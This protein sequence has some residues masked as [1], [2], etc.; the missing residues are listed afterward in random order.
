MKSD[1]IVKQLLL[2]CGAIFSYT[3]YSKSGF[4]LDY[5][6]CYKDEGKTYFVHIF[7]LRVFDN[8]LTY[9]GYSSTK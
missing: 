2:G 9:E 1:D 6:G 4:G 8:I 5:V 7:I 3:Q